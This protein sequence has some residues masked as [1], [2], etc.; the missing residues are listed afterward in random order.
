[1]GITG[2][3]WTVPTAEA[4]LRIRALIASDHWDPYLRFHRRCS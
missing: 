2:A 4:V 3:R 1:M